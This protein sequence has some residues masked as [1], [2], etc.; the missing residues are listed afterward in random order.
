MAATSQPLATLTAL[1]TLERGG[2]AA[3]AAIAAS[4]VLGVT[5]PMSTGIGGDAF[6]IVWRDGE[7]FGLDAAGPAPASAEREVAFVG[8]RSVTVPGAVAGWRMLNERFGRLGLDACLSDAIDVARGGFAVGPRAAAIWAE[9]PAEYAPPARAGEIRRA[10]A[11]AHSLEHLDG[12]YD[13]PI[14]DAIVAASWLDHDDLRT[15]V[16]RWVQPLRL[17]YRDVEVL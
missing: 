15:Y 13:G 14:A 17:R 12:F 2:N 5:E 8:P 10:P 9:P 7:V 11:L 3:D 16:P 1:R 4:A 6:A